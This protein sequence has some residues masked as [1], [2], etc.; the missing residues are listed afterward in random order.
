MTEA[1]VQITAK[2]R[3][4]GQ[5]AGG[6]TVQVYVKAEREGTPNPQLKGFKK[7]HL[8]PAGRAGSDA[9]SAGGCFWSVR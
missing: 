6:E 5:M 1:G 8:Q 4:T 7:V 2:I 3:N 9:P